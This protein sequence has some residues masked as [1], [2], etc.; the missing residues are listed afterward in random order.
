MNDKVTHL[1]RQIQFWTL[2]GPSILLITCL[3]GFIKFAA[4]AYLLPTIAVLGIPACALWRVKGLLLS[5]SALLLLLLFSMGSFPADELIWLTGMGTAIAIGLVVTALSLDEVSDLL[6]HMAIESKSRLD[7]LLRLDARLREAQEK[8]QKERQEHTQQ[9]EE[10]TE[11]NRSQEGHLEGYRKLVPHLETEMKELQLSKQ[12]LMEAS[13]QK[14]QKQ[15]QLEQA[16]QSAQLEIKGLTHAFSMSQE[17]REKHCHT[18]ISHLEEEAQQSER[19][20]LEAQQ[21]LQTLSKE[22][23]ELFSQTDQLQHQIHTQNIQRDK[24]KVQQAQLQQALTSSQQTCEQLQAAN[25]KLQS[26]QEHIQQQKD[27]IQQSYLDLQNQHEALQHSFS[28]LEEKILPPPS[29]SS[30]DAPHQELEEQNRQLDRSVR[31]WEGMYKQLRE[32]FEAKKVT[33]SETRAELFAVEGK[34]FQMEKEQQE[35]EKLQEDP[36][37]RSLQRYLYQVEQEFSLREQQLLQEESAYEELI[38][39]LLHQLSHR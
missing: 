35:L 25:Q 10:L 27:G 18:K 31:H 11:E 23:K 28:N 30:C 21:S 37:Q 36:G 29:P 12:K 39:T 3:A 26:E 6:H 15:A 32:Q 20:L 4:S 16:L 1:E 9:I 13:H 33:L 19:D 5:Q 14:E 22:K 2:L 24:E 17:E 38:T 34:L 7:N 8:S